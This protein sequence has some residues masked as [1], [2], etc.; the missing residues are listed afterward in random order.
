L[1]GRCRRTGGPRGAAGERPVEAAFEL[2]QRVEQQA[3]ED[4]RGEHGDG[5][6]GGDRDELQG[7]DEGLVV[8]RLQADGDQPQAGE[9]EGGAEDRG[10]GGRAGAVVVVFIERWFGPAGAGSSPHGAQGR[11]HA[12]LDEADD[13]AGEDEE[14]GGD[15]DGV[16]RAEVAGLEH[17][18]R[19]GDERGE[20]GVISDP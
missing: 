3:G 15:G 19:A 11:E 10:D 17:A 1:A 6:G 14:G 18:P 2:A 13:G 7:G 8:D 9:G 12:G 5:G 20:D 16:R 4:R